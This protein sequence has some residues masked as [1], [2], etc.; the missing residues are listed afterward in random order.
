MFELGVGPT[1]KHAFFLADVLLFW[2]EKKQ[3]GWPKPFLLVG[4]FNKEFIWDLE[5]QL[6]DKNGFK[7]HQMYS[8]RPLFS[9]ESI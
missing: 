3:L 9:T 4:K 8:S 6:F 1:K 2:G 5:L 7:L